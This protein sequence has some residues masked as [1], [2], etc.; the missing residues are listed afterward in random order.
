MMSDD[1]QNGGSASRE[2]YLELLK[3]VLRFSLWEDPG[4]PVEI[5]AYRAGL[6]RG[7]ILAIAR[8]LAKARLRIVVLR[9][10]DQERRFP[11]ST[12]PACAHSMVSTER[13]NNIQEAV[14]TVIRERVPGDLVETGVWRGGA[15]ILMCAVLKVHG[16]R[17]R[18]VFLADSF[19][20][21]P[22][23]DAAKYPSD[24]RD[25]HYVHE[26]L[27]VSKDEVEENFRK[28][29]LLDDQV[30]FL[31]GWFKDTLP[32][33]PF[34]RLS[35]MRL[36]GDMYESTMDALTSLY[37]KLSPGGFCII[38]DYALEGCRAAVDDF[39]QRQGIT[40]PLVEVDHSGRYWRKRTDKPGAA[41]RQ[42]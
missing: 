17:T 36:D 7:V 4:K 16:D 21:L 1:T 42:P 25:E 18:R 8:L 14:E 26:F 19:A 35:V 37:Q 10:M 23:P 3:K 9:D 24:A 39:R 22:K 30:V 33:A 28:Y 41:S 12:W 6:F 11:G 5:V 20:G 2:L 34:E 13:L 29:G 40:E 15:C 32:T 27:A 38:D 31:K